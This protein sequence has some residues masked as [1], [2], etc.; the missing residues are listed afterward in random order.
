MA[1]WLVHVSDRWCY[2]EERQKNKTL[3]SPFWVLILTQWRTHDVIYS[4]DM[5]AVAEVL[6]KKTTTVG[7]KESLVVF[8]L[9][10][11][12]LTRGYWSKLL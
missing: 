12:T 10:L 6:T 5:Y 11:S 3:I 8:L 7:T 2:Q 1:F 9:K 4:A